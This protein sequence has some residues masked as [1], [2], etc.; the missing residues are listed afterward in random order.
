MIGRV[1]Q[2]TVQ[3]SSLSNLQNNLSAMSALQNKLS[4]TK[5]VT[6]PSDDP[7]GTGSAMALRGALRANE[8]HAR[9][10]ADAEGWL[11]TADAAMTSSLDALRRVR[12]LTVQGASTGTTNAQSREALAVEIEGLRDELLG[13]ANATY[14]GRTV[15]AGTASGAAVTVT[16]P[17]P[18]VPGATQTYTHQGVPGAGVLRPIPAYTQVRVDLDGA[19]VVGDGAALVFA[20]LDR[21]AATLRAGGDVRSE[22][23]ALDGHRD[24][25]LR[26][27]AALGARHARVER[28]SAEA[29]DTRTSLTGRLTAIE[30]ID[31]PKTIV[32][33]QMQEVAYQAALG[34]A[35]RVL[36]PTLM[37]F[38]R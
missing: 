35:G 8:Q 1:T 14:L 20:T 34:A 22:N 9:N 38:L 30:D 37:D 25:M 18:A 6:K 36:Q 23:T 4:G 3:R 21:I 24:A 32:E 10:I 2:Q 16:P 13:Q 27:V 12:A 29:L 17:D 31:L 33:L 28:A 26:E 11:T 5:S 7:A 15:F 19:A